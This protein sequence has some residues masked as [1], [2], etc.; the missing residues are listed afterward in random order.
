[1]AESNDLSASQT[2]KLLQFQDLTR[3]EDLDRCREI[4]NR[5]NWDLEVAV[6][7]TLNIQ[8]GS[9]SVYR[10]PSS[11]QPPVVVDHADQRF[12]YSVQSWRPNG[13]LGWGKFIIT[14]PLSFL[15]NS[16]LGIIK[17]LVDIPT[18]YTVVTDPLADVMNFIEGYETRYGSNHPVFYQGT[19][20]QALN[21]AKRELKFLL[22]YLHGDDHQDT[23]AFCRDTLSN[24]DLVEFINGHMLFW[25]CSVNYPE[26][27]R[28]ALPEMKKT[29][30]TIA[31]TGATDLVQNSKVLHRDCRFF[32]G[33]AT[34]H[35]VVASLFLWVP[36]WCCAVPRDERS[37]TQSIRQQQD[38]AYQASLLADQEK[39][40]RRQEQLRV[41][42][43]EQSRQRERDLVEVQRKQEIQRMKMELVDQIPEEPPDSDP[44]SIRLVIKLPA[45]TRLERRFRRSQSLKYL[46][47][48]VFCQTEAPDSFE[49][50]T[51]F[52]RRT[53][54]CEPTQECPEPPSFAEL[55]LGKTETLFV[56]DLDA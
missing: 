24:R 11:R 17:P 54:P 16:L 13:L 22:I 38:E 44:H 53:L 29:R 36:H 8:E 21:D 12:F 20:S 41:L 26:G 42:E 47:F 10:P 6:Q 30:P 14:F 45:G 56:H 3:I 25:A 40:R 7:D 33:V 43:E 50:I 48:Y 9:P 37:L 55:G 34:V 27:Y 18:L 1:M 51:N 39:E 28:A 2:E 4:L 23:G 35:Q 32:F 19:Y 46:Y 49:I 15:Y 5:H 31:N 52:P